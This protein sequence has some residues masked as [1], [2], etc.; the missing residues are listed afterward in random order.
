METRLDD[1]GQED[2]VNE[3]T[4]MYSLYAPKHFC[5]PGASPAI[6]TEP[7]NLSCV[8]APPIDHKIDPRLIQHLHVAQAEFVCYSALRWSQ[9]NES[10]ARLGI[11]CADGTGAG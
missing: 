2:E 5:Q 1:E 9:F 4:P 6:L 7:A 10:G 11:L 3:T 8:D